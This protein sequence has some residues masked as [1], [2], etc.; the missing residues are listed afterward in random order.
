MCGV[1]GFIAKTDD[2]RPDMAR[3]ER[4]ATATE[5]RGPHAFGFSWIDSRGR[6][7]MFKQTG[8]ISC[9][10]GC[11]AMA[12]DAR[13]LIGHCRWATQGS[14]ENNLNNHPH[15]VD[16]GWL[17]HNGVIPRYDD[18]V[19]GHLLQPVGQCDSE[20]I[21]LLIEELDGTLVERCAQATVA[22]DSPAVVLALWNAPRRLVA[23][24]R[25]N[26]LLIAED[27]GGFYLASLAG[28]LP[29]PVRQVPEDTAL[30]VSYRDG[31]ARIAR[32]PLGEVLSTC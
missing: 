5:R 1:F 8:R 28:G 18:L 21:G 11:L 16:G 13:M 4:I 27:D 29:R 25:G 26:P 20:A 17:V 3:L 31:R 14:P 6:L 9:A 19:E 23:V 22:L 32:H 15:P 12:S 10:L 2:D 30:S 7:R 24:K